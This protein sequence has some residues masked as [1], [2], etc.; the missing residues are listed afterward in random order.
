MWGYIEYYPPYI[1]APGG[2]PPP[3]RF[4]GGAVLSPVFRRLQ[5]IRTHN[6]LIRRSGIPP[7]IVAGVTP[8]RS[9]DPGVFPGL[10]DF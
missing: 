8:L 2:S 6:R 9:L 10:P 3:A 4:L 5:R 7:I 1:G